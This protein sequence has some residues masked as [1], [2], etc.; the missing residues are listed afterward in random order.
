MKNKKVFV[1]IIIA[2]IAVSLSL[3]IFNSIKRLRLLI[4]LKINNNFPAFKNP[5]NLPCQIWYDS[6]TNMIRSLDKFDTI[7]DKIDS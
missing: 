1:G 4:L 5:S 6:R 2:V 3:V 7:D